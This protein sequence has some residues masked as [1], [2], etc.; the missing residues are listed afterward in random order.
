LFSRIFTTYAMV[1]M[2]LFMIE[3]LQDHTRNESKTLGGRLNGFVLVSYFLTPKTYFWTSRFRCILKYIYT[4]HQIHGKPLF[5]NGCRENVL[6]I[7]WKQVFSKRG[8]FIK[9]P[10]TV[11]NLK[12]WLNNFKLTGAASYSGYIRIQI[13]RNK[14]AVNPQLKLYNI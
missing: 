10:S 3:M 12:N 1:C 14:R 8:R 11:Q 13:I 7:A 4:L 6:R 2:P 9:S 5:S